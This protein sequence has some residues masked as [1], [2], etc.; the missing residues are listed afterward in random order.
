ME[1]GE[2]DNMAMKSKTKPKYTT[3]ERGIIHLTPLESK[4]FKR[5]TLLV[6]P[7]LL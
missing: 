7:V 2:E 4:T 5:V 3:V 6:L 1:V